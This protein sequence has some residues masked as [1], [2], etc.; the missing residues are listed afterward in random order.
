[1]A[2]SVVWVAVS[3]SWL[4]GPPLAGI[5]GMCRPF[6]LFRWPVVGRHSFMARICGDDMTRANFL[7]GSSSDS[8]LLRARQ[9]PLST[10]LSGQRGCGHCPHPV[11]RRLSTCIVVPSSWFCLHYFMKFSVSGDMSLRPRPAVSL[12]VPVNGASPGVSVAG[13][14]SVDRAEVCGIPAFFRA[15][16]VWLIRHTCPNSAA[17]PSTCLSESALQRP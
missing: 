12:D 11:H 9:T 7:R 8:C 10:C 4:V 2:C 5:W 14:R 15:V 13:A 6:L 1:V 17:R 16:L 3:G